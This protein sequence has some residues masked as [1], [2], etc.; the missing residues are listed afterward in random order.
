MRCMS[1]G[2]AV[3]DEKSS[4]HFL[5]ES[6]A[7]WLHTMHHGCVRIIICDFRCECGNPILYGGLSKTEFCV[8]LQH[9]LIRELL[10]AWIFDL[11]GMGIPFRDA[12]ASCKRKALGTS[13][14]TILVFS[15]PM[16]T[17]KMGN[18]A[19]NLFLKTLQFSNDQD[20]YQ[21]FSCTNCL[22]DDRLGNLVWSGVVMD[23]T[24]TGFWAN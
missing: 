5:S 2:I 24:E 11:R 1:Q 16:L 13:A 23:R 7:A 6:R 22:T 9:V 10:D 20:L 3:V 19:F 14:R 21:V 18:V 12:F 8:N 15:P 4:P 17:H